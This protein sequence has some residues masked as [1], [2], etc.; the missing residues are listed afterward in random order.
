MGCKLE[1]H[2]RRRMMGSFFTAVN[3]FSTTWVG[4]RWTVVPHFAIVSLLGV[5]AAIAQDA[6]P[7]IPEG[8][9]DEAAQTSEE[10]THDKLRQFRTDMESIVDSGEW[11]GLR[12]FLASNVVVTWIDGTQSHGADDVLD[13]LRSKTEGD[14]A[15]VD[16]F[17]LS[18]EI[19]D[20]SD[21]YGQ[22][23]A[24]AFGTAESS[25]V[26]RGREIS[27]TGPW[28]ATLVKEANQWK[29]ASLSSS[30]G[31]FDNSLLSWLYRM[32][33]LIGGGAGALGLIAGL[34]LGRRSRSASST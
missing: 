4:R 25:F 9:G 30:V 10:A 6:A 23:T 24:I 29:L 32:L 7:T 31:F 33:W 15:I 18:T 16:R 22:D 20:L 3:R 11:E 8:A 2:A 5:S 34:L 28:S 14:D 13:Y 26:L 12:P 19:A 21:L 27:V 1:K 17:S